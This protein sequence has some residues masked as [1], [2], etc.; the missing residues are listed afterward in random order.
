MATR[1]SALSTDSYAAPGVDQFGH[2]NSL[3]AHAGDMYRGKIIADRDGVLNHIDTGYSITPHNGIITFAF[4]DAAHATGVYNNPQNGFTEQ[5]GYTPF[6]DAQRGAARLAI[7]SWDDLIAPTFK[8]V[9]GTGG[10]DITYQ[11]TTTGPAQAWAYYPTDYDQPQLRHLESDVWTAS[12]AVNSSNGNLFSGGYGLVTLEHETGHTLGLS[13][14]GNYNGAGATTYLNQAE[15]AQDSTQYSIMSYWDAYETGAS[16]ID[17]SVMRFTYASTP[18]VHDVMVIQEK[19]G[20]DMTTR[21]G[22]TTY[23]FNATA[24]VTN[25]AMVFT[26]GERAAI[27][28]IWDAAGNDTLNLSGYATASTIDL[29]PGSYSS[30]GGADHLQT[31]VEINANNAAAGFGPRSAFLYEVYFHG[32]A[33]V[34]GGQSWLNVTHSTDFLMHNNIGIAYGATIENAIGGGGNDVIG[35]NDV[36]NML[37]GNGGNDILTGLLGN[38]SLFGGAGD[39]TLNGGAGADTLSGGAGNDNF[40]FTDLQLGDI[41]SDYGAGDHIDLTALYGGTMHFVGSAALSALGDVNYVNGVISGNFAGDAGADFSAVLSGMP[42]LQP[43]A[44]VLHG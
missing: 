44:L 42:A 38:D 7:Q 23:G 22:D 40:V 9:N 4:A 17:W 8:E 11:N 36:S 41:I 43:D 39:D 26:L 25:P 24:D 13:H 14:P 37:T 31:L 20:A 15:Y 5:Y 35:G 28:T 6:S 10:A 34:N 12:P 1:K 3:D 18:M 27:F 16:S 33:G 21:T 29:R 2:T 32:V 30:A 19:Y